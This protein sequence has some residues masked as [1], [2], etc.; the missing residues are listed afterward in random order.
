MLVVR[1]QSIAPILSPLLLSISL[2]LPLPLS[3]IAHRSF[4]SYFNRLQRAAVASVGKQRLQAAQC[5][6]YAAASAT[7]Q[8]SQLQQQQ[9]HGSSQLQQQQQQQKQQQR[10]Q[11]K[12]QQQQQQQ[13]RLHG[14]SQLQQ[15]QQQ[16]LHGSSQLLSTYVYMNASAFAAVFLWC[17]IHYSHHPEPYV[18]A[19]Y[20]KI[21]IKCGESC[22]CRLSAV[23]IIEEVKVT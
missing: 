13:Q 18:V 23:N 17:A 21:V 19:P 11:Q 14:S 9:L 4:S 20:P 8:Y 12:Q 22:M 1:N 3:C 10:Q 2:F 7:R 5:S 6:C 15:Q 16:Q